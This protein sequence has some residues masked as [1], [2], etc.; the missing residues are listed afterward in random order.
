MIRHTLAG[1]LRHVEGVQTLAI[2]GTVPYPRLLL[3]GSQRIV[4]SFVLNGIFVELIGRRLSVVG[5]LLG[6]GLVG[7]TDQFEGGAA[8]LVASVLQ[9]M[10]E[11]GHSH[12]KY[13]QQCRTG[14]G[15]TPAANRSADQA[16]ASYFSAEYSIF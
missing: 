8:Q 9:Y 3:E 2:L 14:A 11:Y 15:G 13:H 1:I 7:V 5:Q 4:G 16:A 12:R 10:L 6:E